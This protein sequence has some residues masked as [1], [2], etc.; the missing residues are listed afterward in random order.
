MATVN[1]A[2]DETSN[3]YAKLYNPFMITLSKTPITINYPYYFIGV[4]LFTLQG[5]A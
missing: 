2:R 3:E 4:R 1:R 5:C